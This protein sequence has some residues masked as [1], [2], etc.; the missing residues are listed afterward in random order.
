MLCYSAIVSQGK[1]ILLMIFAAVLLL[2]VAGK[3]V[4]VEYYLW[5][6]RMSQGRVTVLGR[7]L[8]D[9]G[10]SVRPRVIEAFKARGAEPNVADFRVAVADTLHCLRHDEVAKAIGS[11]SIEKVYSANI[12]VDLE[13]AETIAA[14]FN[15][16]PGCRAKE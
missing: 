4:L 16:E 10:S 13:A 5:R 2:G 6:Y 15:H 7:P 12:P 11:S 1:K 8:C 14:A 3:P 9:L